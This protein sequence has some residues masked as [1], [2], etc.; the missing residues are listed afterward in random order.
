MASLVSGASALLA[1]ALAPA[2]AA[3]YQRSWSKFEQFARSVLNIAPF[4]ASPSSIALFIAH[5][6]SPPQP[7]S[8]ATIATYISALAYVHKLKGAPDPTNDFLIRKILKGA[9]KSTQ[10]S[11]LRVPVTPPMLLALIRA[12]SNVANSPHESCLMQAMFST[13]FHAFLRIGEV[14]TSPHNILTSQVVV[15]PST[16]SITFL[17]FK[18]HCGQPFT[19]S[20]PASS[21]TEVCPVLLLS[22]YLTLRGR[23]DGPLFCHMNNAPI[24]PAKFREF[25]NIANLSSSHITPHSFRIGAATYAATQGSSSQQ[26]QAMGRWKSSAFQKYIRVRSISFP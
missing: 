8:T 26:I 11:D 15:L 17:S 4:P 1:A 2:S 7:S 16:V 3:Q 23:A 13:M 20:I 24:Q 6:A 21:S 9:S 5:L 14:T 19:L 25:L 12:A 10:A 18:H 22:R